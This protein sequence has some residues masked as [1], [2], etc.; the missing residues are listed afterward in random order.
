MIKPGNK[1]RRN[2]D[3]SIMTIRL[4]VLPDEENHELTYQFQFIGNHSTYENTEKHILQWY[5]KIEE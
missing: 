1:F 4:A 3:G 2:N 5:T